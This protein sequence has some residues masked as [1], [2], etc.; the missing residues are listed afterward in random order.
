MARCDEG[1]RC[2]VCGVEV[3]EI[4]ESDLYL[5]YVLGEV[6]LAELNSAPE[7]HIRC[8]PT[9]AQFI[10]DDRFDPVVVEGAF[11]KEGLDRE[12]VA[13]REQ[14]VTRAWRR[15]KELAQQGVPLEEYPLPEFRKSS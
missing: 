8:N 2:S 9:Q 10:V 4:T 15:L 7:R 6:P 12:E 1:Y 5:G 13:R 14:L 3:E 11:A